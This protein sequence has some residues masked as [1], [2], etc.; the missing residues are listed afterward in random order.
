MQF[1]CNGH[2]WLA[3]QLQREEIEFQLLGNAF[4]EIADLDRA[5]LLAVNLD[6]QWLHTRFP[7]IYVVKIILETVK[8][9]P[10]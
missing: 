8:R 1:Y 2:T 7:R 5:N 4:L 6:I 9:E 10:A 3:S